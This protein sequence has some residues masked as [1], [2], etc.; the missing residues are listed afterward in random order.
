MKIL[1][2]FVIGPVRHQCTSGWKMSSL[3]PYEYFCHLFNSSSHVR[4]T[5]SLKPPSEYVAQR[6]MYPW[7]WS[8]KAISKS[9]L[10][11]DSDQIFF[12]PS[13]GSTKAAS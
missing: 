5:P 1:S 11:F 8:R 10:T 7:S 4:D 3:Q 13:S 6:M 2:C 9:S 12:T